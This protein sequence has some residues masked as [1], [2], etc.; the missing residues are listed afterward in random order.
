LRDEELGGVPDPE[1]ELEV[2]DLVVEVDARGAPHHDFFGPIALE[3]LYG[4]SVHA[5]GGAS[6]S[7]LMVNDAA[8]ICRPPDGYVV[9]A[10]EIEDGRDGL[11]EMRSAKHVAAEVQHDGMGLRVSRRHGQPPGAILGSGR[12]IVKSVDLAEVLLV[13]ERHLVLLARPNDTRIAVSPLPF[14]E[15]A[16]RDED[17]HGAPS[18][19]A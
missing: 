19:A 11:H 4:A 13:V 9:E 8:A 10:E 7:L 6:I 5:S 14:P 16:L 12:E 3:Q 18:A 17:D 2:T 15:A 1:R